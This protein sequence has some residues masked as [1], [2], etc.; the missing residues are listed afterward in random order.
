MQERR[1]FRQS[2][3]L[4]SP[5]SLAWADGLRSKFSR[6]HFIFCSIGGRL[7]FFLRT[8]LPRWLAHVGEVEFLARDRDGVAMHELQQDVTATS[9]AA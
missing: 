7:A 9:L 6:C 3:M 8:Q 1:P 5:I 4:P 2:C